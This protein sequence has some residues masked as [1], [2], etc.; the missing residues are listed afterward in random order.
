MN[1]VLFGSLALSIASSL[2]ICTLSLRV[3][4]LCR[5]KKREVQEAFSAELWGQD[6]LAPVRDTI[7]ELIE[8]TLGLSCKEFRL[9][10]QVSKV[11]GHEDYSSMRELISK[12]G[13]TAK[14]GSAETLEISQIEQFV[15]AVYQFQIATRL[16]EGQ[17]RNLLAPVIAN[18][19]G[20]KLHTKTIGKVD[21]VEHKTRVDETLMWPL[22]QGLRV[23]QPYGL[24]IRS[25]RD[26]ILS[27]AKVRC[28]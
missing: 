13:S 16:S 9:D 10:A 27:R 19:K 23:Q 3:L 8:P 18:L 7:F 12:M 17:T 20:R 15:K 24:I 2:A 5:E 14:F 1:E 28:S 4:T 11:E 21:F 25:D 22:N 6:I 26:E